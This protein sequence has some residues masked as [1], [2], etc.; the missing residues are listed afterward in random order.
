MRLKKVC[1]ILV[2]AVM[3]CGSLTGLAASQKNLDNAVFEVTSLG[4]MT[5]DENGALNLSETM[6]RAEFA[7][8]AAVMSGCGSAVS[9][10]FGTEMLRD[11]SADHWAAGYIGYCV[12]AG[13]MGGDG[14]GGFRPDDP[15]TLEECIKTVVSILGYEIVAGQDGGYP[16][17]YYNVAVKKHLLDGVTGA[18]AEPAIRQDIL[19]LIWNAL[20]VPNLV[21]DYADEPTYQEDA[22]VTVRSTIE[23][24]GKLK[25][26]T[27]VVTA[28]ADIWLSQERTDMGHGQVE[29][30]GQLFDAGETRAADYI[31][32]EVVA[33]YVDSDRMRNPKLH[34]IQP[35]THNTVTEIQAEG[36]LTF[37]DKELCYW[38]MDSRTERRVT[39]S[40]NTLFVYNN[41]ISTRFLDA[42][43]KIKNGD[44][45][46][47][48]NTGDRQV[49]LVFINEYESYVV[50]KANA[51]GNLKVKYLAAEDGKLAPKYTNILLDMEVEN[52]FAIRGESGEE[53]EYESLKPG[54]VVSVFRNSMDSYLRIVKSEAEVVTGAAAFKGD[55]D[56]LT[57]DGETYQTG[58]EDLYRS[59]E[60]GEIYDFYIDA[61]GRIVYA[62][63]SEAKT[64]QESVWQYG[65]ILGAQEMQFG[66]VSIQMLN[67][68]LVE[69]REEENF[70]DRTDKETIPVTLCKNES[71]SYLDAAD[72]LIVDGQSIKEGKAVQLT[73]RPVRY[74][75]NAAG[76]L[77]RIQTFEMVGG[78]TE[79]QYSAKEK[80]F[81]GLRNLDP[82]MI[83][84]STR[85][86]CIP[87]NG[88]TAKEDLMVRISL[89]NKD[90]LLRYN[91]QGY[92][93]DEETG[94]VKLMV[95]TKEMEASQ[96]EGVYQNSSKL[97]L[98]Q[99]A[100]LSVDEDG[101]EYMTVTMMVGSELK[102][103]KTLPLYDRP[104]LRSLKSGDFIF[105]SDDADGR[106]TNA[107]VAKNVH[108][109]TAG[110]HSGE[111]SLDEQIAGYVQD[112]R[113]N[114]IDNINLKQV[115][116]LDVV[117]EDGLEYV[118]VPISNYPDIFIYYT[119][120]DQVET[121]TIDDIIPYSTI[122]P[123]PERVL[124]IMPKAS[125]R[126]IVII[127]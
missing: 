35:T 10:S 117:T 73:G 126:G 86:I 60:L 116:E 50:E 70:A 76:E 90:T 34:N 99:D 98:I 105:F 25:K 53:L 42:Y 81:G 9:G 114:K 87:K 1:S 40:A 14:D 112:I 59:V 83:N 127:K 56:K 88:S 24:A 49:N 94:A 45:R 31:G 111:D 82:F 67:A 96:V 64:A 124:I 58:N 39:L 4:I 2:V 69:N 74:A 97:G 19:F 103:V 30:D 3:L 41:R 61:F 44:I 43:S 101:E 32:Q 22:N 27:G 102:E 78:G 29:I 51:N 115:N 68:G 125:I 20:D 85:V 62:E 54:D 92:D 13:L 77:K 12:G 66:S 106:I 8:T 38:E 48:D 16:R 104:E 109:V 107:I 72:T 5:G 17:G 33:Y 80:V 37:T 28:N 7:K 6:T 23:N 100:G 47:I 52:G 122:E 15:I 63:K 57:V 120:T 91:A 11:V 21:G 71:I 75:L 113:L 84:E 26:L 118:K 18:Q 36:L 89:D 108:D 119:A 79:M 123:N 95:I 93:L 55:D 121:G 46:M 110:Y 65:Y